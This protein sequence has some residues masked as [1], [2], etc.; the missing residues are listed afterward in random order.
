[1]TPNLVISETSASDCGWGCAIKGVRRN[2]C[3]SLLAGL[4][5]GST[6]VDRRARDLISER[7]RNTEWNNEA[8]L[9][10][11]QQRFCASIKE[12]F[13]DKTQEQYLAITSSSVTRQELGIQSGKLVFTGEEIAQLF[14]PSIRAMEQSIAAR[15]Q[16]RGQQTVPVAMVGGFSE[17]A[18]LRKEVQARLGSRVRLCKPDEATAKA[19]AN[20][21]VAW[22]I[23]G[24]VN[25]RVARQTYGIRCSTFYREGDPVHEARKSML[26]TGNDGKLRLPSSFGAVIK[27][28]QS[29]S[30]QEE[31]L[32]KFTFS[33]HANMPLHKD[34]S[35]YVY[36][37]VE[38]T[39][40]EFIDLG[41]L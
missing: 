33:W 10:D 27:K 20:G 15:V 7:L 31:H 23:D 24:V 18:F 38:E 14:E 11:F 32:E 13:S 37:G 21:G 36:R 3:L 1:M 28:D 22:L 8:D 26:I 4:L 19:V 6:T 12:A 25:T 29:G 17:S 2:D 39:E 40:P 41:E 5:A 30:E 35:L 9:D 34:I 16:G